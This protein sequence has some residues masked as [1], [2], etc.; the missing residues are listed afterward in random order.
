MLLNA[1]LLTLPYSLYFKEPNTLFIGFATASFVG[2]LFP[3][4]DEPNSYIG[5]RT[6]GL[7]D[8]INV[9]F[10]HRGITHFLIVPIAIFM[11]GYFTGSILEQMIIYGF[12]FGW[13]THIMGDGLTKGGVK[14]GLFPFGNFALLPRALRFYTKSGTEYL[15]MFFMTLYISLFVYAN[16]VELGHES[17]F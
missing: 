17:I 16:L 6:R 13:F 8:L 14:Y 15:L 2:T 12:A 7:S 11:L 5:R 10:N 1:S 3:D 4:I 9:I